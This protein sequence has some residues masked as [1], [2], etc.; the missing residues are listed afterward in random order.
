[1]GET[2][3]KRGWILVKLKQLEYLLKIVECGSITK[4][5]RELYISQPSLTKSIVSLEEEY[6]IQ[7]LIRKPRG[8][9]LT[10]DG[11]N[12][13]YYARSV[14]AAANALEQNFTNLQGTPRSRLFLATQQ[15]DFVHDLFFKTYLQNQDKRIHYNLVET[16]RNDVTRQV[17]SG[18]V[19]LGLL[20]RNVADA[21]TF[22]VNAEAKRLSVHSIGR[23]GVYAAV[24]PYSPFYNQ[25]KITFEEAENCA[26]LV[27]D[28]EAQATQNL[29]FDNI[30]NHFNTDKIIFVNSIVA[31]ERFL[32]QSD[33]L[34]FVAKW[35]EG[36]FRDPRIQVIPVEYEDGQTPGDDINELLWIKRA[37]EP[38]NFTEFHFLQLLYRRFGKEEELNE[39]LP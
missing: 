15:L 27:L 14:L 37:G 38:L 33:L 34:L 7:I 1:M 3:R 39:L 10:S 32:I 2:H 12:F 36:C 4:A 23:S 9:E 24:G 31:C 17:L 11:K 8:V 35:A 21:K 13:V 18:N 28:M 29:Y 20:V 30:S 22:L 6:K 25:K 5:A 19:D 26:Q 16:D